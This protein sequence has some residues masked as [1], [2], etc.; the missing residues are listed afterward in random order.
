[1][2]IP[3][4]TQDWHPMSMKEIFKN[5]GV[6]QPSAKSFIES[7]P[8]APDDITAG[9]EIELQSAVIGDRQNVDL[10]LTIEHSNYFANIRRRITTG[11]LPLARGAS[12]E[13]WLHHNADRVWENSWVRAPHHALSSYARQ[14]VNADLLA[15][16]KHP[17]QGSRTDR[18]KFTC[19]EKGRGS[20]R[21]PVSYLLKLALA[22]A[23][24]SGPAMPAALLP[25][26]ERLM[27]HLLNDNTSPE[28]SSFNITALHPDRGLGRALARETGKRFLL[29]QL[30]MQYANEQ[31]QLKA[32]GQNALV[33]FS[34]HPPVRQKVLNECIPDSFYRELFMSPC[35]SGW[36][37][38]EAKHHYMI[39]CHQVLSRSQLNATANLREAGIIG[40]QRV[41][42]P[43]ISNI[44]LA[45][46]GA[47]VSL[48]SK[49]LTCAL[50][51][52]SSGFAAAHE[53]YIGDLAVKITEHFLPLFIGTY[54]ADPYRLGFADFLP[55]K[56]L[57]FLPHELDYTHLRMLW[58]RWK[59]KA[60]LRLCGKSFLPSGSAWLDNVVSR[61]FH[62]QGDFID[63]F[64]L[65]DYPVSLLSTDR[66]PAFNGRLGNQERL[67]QDLTELGVFDGKMSFYC[68]HRLR[69]F[70]AMG[71]SGFEGRWYSL[72]ESLDEDMSRAVDLQTLITA[73][74]YK[75]MA[76]GLVTHAHIPDTPSIESERRQMFF[77]T[78]IGLP[79]FFVRCDTRNAFL[80]RILQYVPDMR[81][82]RRY[83]GYWRVSNLEYRLAL[84]KLLRQD[85]AD[86]IENLRLNETLADLS[87][88]LRDPANASAAGKLT[89]GIL[90]DLSAQS[91]LQVNAA[92]FNQAAERYYRE[93]LRKSHIREALDNIR[94]D[95]RQIDAGVAAEMPAC[96][97]ILQ[98]VLQGQSAAN[99]PARLRN[100][101]LAETC[102]AEEL[103][104]L[105]QLLIVSVEIDRRQND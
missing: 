86:L 53:K 44:S 98:A 81:S 82:S 24:S 72:F 73:L 11:D 36:D 74:A 79:T 69:E 30:L 9:T 29:T 3:C 35:L 88:R 45:N 78:A 16:N 33:Y 96:R 102:S 18:H 47:H 57:G 42:L 70:R 64:R 37:R 28:S 71:F 67:K 66:S 61:G 14:I 77:S 46:N 32:T 103:R 6:P 56:V 26:A 101:I 38:G 12:L 91:P 55:E 85:A 51:N 99:L 17:E 58:R 1:M 50:K 19:I 43:T 59:K 41:S 105:I 100:R 13:R 2:G 52:V 23:V 48:G 22:D 20:L 104:K 21:I 63:D 34:P 31:F 39:L 7:L 10:P 49:R 95:F 40:G 89:R 62:A 60:H 8:F 27:R 25:I 92:E 87:E 80:R 97:E 84:I 75:Y 83:Q 68:L 54:S 15:D 76:G 4:H 90:H 93:T 5:L 94:L 65:I